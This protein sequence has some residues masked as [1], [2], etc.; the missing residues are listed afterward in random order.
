MNDLADVVEEVIG[1]EVLALVQIKVHALKIHVEQL[2][3]DLHLQLN[4]CLA[5]PLL[6]DPVDLALDRRL[7]GLLRGLRIDNLYNSATRTSPAY[8]NGSRHCLHLRRRWHG[9]RECIEAV[10]LLGTS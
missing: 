5:E 9:R 4:R 8:F 1:G 7:D 6:F 2:R 3:L 10:L